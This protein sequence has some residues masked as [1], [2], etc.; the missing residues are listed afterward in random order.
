MVDM[1]KGMVDNP[2]SSEQSPRTPQPGRHRRDPND[3]A[4]D[5]SADH[6]AA[7]T[8]ELEDSNATIIYLRNK[9]AADTET[10][11]DTAVD[12]SAENTDSTT[13]VVPGHVRD[14]FHAPTQD[15]ARQLGPAWDYGWRIGST[16]LIHVVHPDR[17]AWSARVRETLK[18]NGVR[19]VR[20]IR[21]TDG[22]FINA[23]WRASTY[24]A[25]NPARRVD[26]TVAAAL[27]LDTALKEVPI[28]DSLVAW[29]ATDV[30]VVADRAAWGEEPVVV[31]D[32]EIPAHETALRLVSR[33]RRF[34]RDLVDAD[35]AKLPVQVTHA[36]MFATT[37]YSGAQAP[38]VTDLVGVVHP[39][40]Y[41]AA[42]TI[43]DAL[44]MNAVDPGVIDRYRHIEHL[45]QLLV[46]ALLY[47]L[48]VHALHPDA[49]AN[50]GTNLEWVT[51]VVT[52][53]V[54]VRM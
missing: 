21:S 49:T 26:E 5:N 22:R 13:L 36:D 1:L 20:P 33:V 54:D 10:D 51:Q 3:T 39:F 52:G 28:P 19:M 32:P 34:W 14:V 43:V 44:M 6:V 35:G 27:R 48:Y 42:Q 24:I 18:V 53:K 15:E 38:A 40:G 25:G 37:I 29:D 7:D 30:F 4:P 23:G 41:T 11:T 47:R 2:S 45:D 8:G 9:H 17:A 31:L 16:V 50:T 46:R 12:T